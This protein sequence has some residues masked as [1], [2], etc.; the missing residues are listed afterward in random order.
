MSATQ[1]P[2]RDKEGRLLDPDSGKFNCLANYCR[3]KFK[4]LPNPTILAVEILKSISNPGVEASGASMYHQA[5]DGCRNLL[6][7]DDP[8]A[9][10]GDFIAHIRFFR[11][12]REANENEFYVGLPSDFEGDVILERTLLINGFGARHLPEA[13]KIQ[14][15]QHVLKCAVCKEWIDIMIWAEDE[16]VVGEVPWDLIRERAKYVVEEEETDIEEKEQKPNT[17]KED[18]GRSKGEGKNND[19]QKDKSSEQ[20]VVWEDPAEGEAEDT[21]GRESEDE[22]EDEDED[23]I[24]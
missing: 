24:L 15:I 23:I 20:Y 18:F 2:K 19:E 8:T 5:I 1:D 13:L 9:I 4:N 7:G 22:D 6:F 11:G 14:A 10:K 16:D 21:W 12:S 17:Q 3:P